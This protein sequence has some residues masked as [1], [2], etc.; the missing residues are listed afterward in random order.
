M[1]SL[2]N[3][4][5]NIMKVIKFFQCLNMSLHGFTLNLQSD[6]KLIYR[7]F[8]LAFVILLSVL[9]TILVAKHLF[10]IYPESL[11]DCLSPQG[12]FYSLYIIMY[13]LKQPLFTVCICESRRSNSALNLHTRIYSTV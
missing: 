11:W 4:F 12:V 1:F 9:L 8:L 3:I 7:L 2:H 13:V 10:N 6:A 5:L